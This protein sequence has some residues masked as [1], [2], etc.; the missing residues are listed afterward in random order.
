MAQSVARSIDDLI[1]HRSYIVSAKNSNGPTE[2]YKYIEGEKDT[3]MLISCKSRPDGRYLGIKYYRKGDNIVGQDNVTISKNSR[4]CNRVRSLQAPVGDDDTPIDIYRFNYHFD[5]PFI[6]DSRGRS[7][8][9]IVLDALNNKSVYTYTR[10]QRLKHIDKFSSDGNLY[11]RE[12]LYWGSY[13]SEQCSYL[14]SRSLA[15]SSG[16]L[17]FARTYSYDERGNVLQDAL[18][19]N[20]SGHS[21]IAPI[22][23][24]KGVVK[25]NG[26]ENFQKQYKYSDDGFNLLLWES[27]GIHETSYEYE[28]ESNRLSA[29]FVGE[30]NKIHLR[31]FYEYNIEAALTK[32]I[33]DDGFTKDKNNLAGVTERHI[34]DYLPR[35]S[36]PFGYPEVVIEKYLDIASGQEVLKNKVVNTHNNQGLLVKQMHYDSTDTYLYTLSW[37]YNPMGKLT[38]EVDA[39]QRVSEW[40]YDPNGNCIYEQGP[41]RNVNKSFVYD[42]ANRLIRQEEVHSDGI[43]RD[44]SYRYNL[45]SQPV[46]IRDCNGNETHYSY[47]AFGRVTDIAFPPVMDEAGVLSCPTLKKSYD[48]MGNVTSLIDSKGNEKTVSYTIR[49][50]IAKVLY[51]DGSSESNIYN[52]DGSLKSSCAKNGTVT[53]FTYDILG[54]IIKTEI[55]SPSGELL[56]TTSASYNKWCD[57][58]RLPI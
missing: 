24:D 49:G 16:S 2:S 33:V 28:Q 25:E 9:T 50:Q 44:I 47:D 4:R 27:D 40:Y 19:G 6:L 39:L 37:E 52:L 45:L 17:A 35:T 7:G 41:D 22:I 15:S 26:C 14:L 38:R 5:L 12:T 29:K 21:K 42:F 31:E 11:S 43:R 56:S 30:P 46:V 57:K 55:T 8:S 10:D 58:S 20:L 32:K 18:Y 54:R 13:K 51:L 34:T 48:L 53:S 36:Y 1:L 23:S 3:G